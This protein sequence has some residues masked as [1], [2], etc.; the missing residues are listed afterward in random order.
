MSGFALLLMLT[1]LLTAMLGLL[2][3]QLAAFRRIDLPDAGVHRVS[4]D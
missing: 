1:G 4:P 3:E 2:A